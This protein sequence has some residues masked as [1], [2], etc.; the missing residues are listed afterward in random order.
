MTSGGTCQGSTVSVAGL[1][2]QQCIPVAGYGGTTSQA[3]MIDCANNEVV[4]NGY[5]AQD[6]SGA[7]TSSAVLASTGTC[8]AY[9]STM[10]E[11]PSD[12]PL[13][14]TAST[15]V[16][17]TCGTP[18]LS[19]SHDFHTPF[20]FFPLFLCFKN[21]FSSPFTLPSPTRTLH[22]PSSSFHHV[23][24]LN[25]GYDVEKVYI[26]ADD[27][28]QSTCNLSSSTAYDGQMFEVIEHTFFYLTHLLCA[29]LKYL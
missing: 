4:L 1:A 24:T 20:L 19:V 25:Q 8:Y 3:F 22:L 14:D 12:T 7:V 26:T 27:S 11:N 21:F 9:S 28:A 29:L 2:G 23:L 17:F 13:S 18:N 16:T 15:S 6:C 10:Y 5:S